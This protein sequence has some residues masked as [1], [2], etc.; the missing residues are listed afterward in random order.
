[1]FGRLYRAGANVNIENLGTIQFD[2]SVGNTASL[3]AKGVR[4]TG[5][6]ANNPPLDLEPER[7]VFHPDGTKLFVNL[8]DNSGVGVLDVATLTWDFVDGYG[9]QPQMYDASNE[10]GK[11]NI[12]DWGTFGVNMPDG[13]DVAVVWSCAS[14]QVRGPGIAHS[15]RPDRCTVPD[16]GQDIPLHR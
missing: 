10:D 4:L 3:L 13:V 11:I 16:W 8:Q 12:Q 14:R 5:A 1:M 7:A 9:F 6:N 2:A 15:L